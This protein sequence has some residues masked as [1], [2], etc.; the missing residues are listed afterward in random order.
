MV[1]GEDKA[2]NG[3]LDNSAFSTKKS[4]KGTKGGVLESCNAKKNVYGVV[5]LSPHGIFQK[6]A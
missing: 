4:E 6:E 1:Y 2:T 5:R 3:E